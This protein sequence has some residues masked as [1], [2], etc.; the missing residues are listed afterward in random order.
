MP[1]PSVQLNEIVYSSDFDKLSIEVTGEVDSVEQ[2]GLYLNDLD[3]P[4]WTPQLG[5][6]FEP[7]Y[8]DSSWF[9]NNYIDPAMQT[10]WVHW[11]VLNNSSDGVLQATIVESV[12]IDRTQS[13]QRA[14]I[15]DRELWQ[16][17]K[18]TTLGSSNDDVTML[19]GEVP[20][21]EV[22]ALYQNYPNPFNGSTTITFDLLQPATVSLWVT[23]ARGRIVDVFGEK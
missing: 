16:S 4:I 12:P 2:Y 18:T 22:F 13:L 10:L 5:T 7:V 6:G 3:E 20:I 17:T 11:A 23:D 19:T 21:P 14:R 1:Q 9:I 8:L 15:P